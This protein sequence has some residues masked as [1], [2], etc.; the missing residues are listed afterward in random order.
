[1]SEVIAGTKVE[2]TEEKKS[3]DVLGFRSNRHKSS[4]SV[5]LRNTQELNRSQLFFRFCFIFCSASCTWLCSCVM[6]VKSRAPHS[7]PPL[8]NAAARL[9]T[10]AEQVGGGSGP[11]GSPGRPHTGAVTVTHPGPGAVTN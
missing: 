6:S 1:M 11:E 4:V 5:K 7:G 9:C 10:R 2:E 3:S 8:T